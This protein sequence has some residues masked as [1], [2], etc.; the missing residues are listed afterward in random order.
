MIKQLQIANFRKFLQV[1][2]NL[3]GLKVRQMVR[4]RNW[5][6]LSTLKKVSMLQSKVSLEITLKFFT[7]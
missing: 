4:N 5:D 6:C 3:T 2:K 1:K 7:F